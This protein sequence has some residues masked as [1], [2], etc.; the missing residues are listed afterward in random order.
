MNKQDI[1]AS[2]DKCIEDFRQLQ[3]EGLIPLS[4]DFF[5]GGTHYPLI[6]QYPEISQE[7]AY[8]GYSVPKDGMTDLYVH[9]PFC[10]QRCIFCHYPAQYKAPDEAKDKYVDAIEKEFELVKRQFGVEKIKPRVILVGGGTPTDLS[11][12]QLERFL[13]ILA[14]NCDMTKLM[15]YNFDVSPLSII[16]EIGKQ[17]LQILKDFGVDRLTIGLQTTDKKILAT[18]NRNHTKEEGLESVSVSKS[19]GFQTEVEY[20]YGYPGQTL[21]SW[22]NELQEIARTEA[23]EIQF[24]RLKVAAYGDQQGTIKKYTQIHKSELPSVEDTI[25][26]RRMIFDCLS[27]FG[28]KET[29][30]R[31]FAKDKSKFSYY[32]YNQY[33]EMYDETGLGTSAF[34]SLHDRFL[35]N[36]ASFEEYYK[37]IE[38]GKLPLNRGIVRDKATQQRWALVL[39]LKNDYLKK[40]LYKQVTGVKIEDTPLYNIIQKHKEYSLLEEDENSIRLTPKGIMFADEI[41]ETFYSTRYQPIE[42]KFYNDGEL[43]PYTLS[44]KFA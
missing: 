19:F 6:T 41:I 4:D 29:L 3:K 31:I 28:W 27:E 16:G 13:Q 32:L 5:P 42:R 37:R 17:R 26:M 8:R 43:N 15:Q 35:I 30:R 40:D 39:P 7:E 18:M 33:C 1:F 20:I 23:D 25:R 12:K 21:D 9:L 44:E 11:P 14:K 34:S 22:Y 10:M 24:Y 38:E 36:T 2:A